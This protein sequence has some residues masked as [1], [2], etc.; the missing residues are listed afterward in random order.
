MK[1]IWIIMLAAIDAVWI[2]ASIREFIRAVKIASKWE[3]NSVFECID[4]F[5]SEVEDYA[6]ACFWSH[7]LILFVYSLTLFI[8][9]SGVAE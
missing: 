8:M 4:D 6:H 1:Y 7:I 9:S 2:I 5:M 3:F